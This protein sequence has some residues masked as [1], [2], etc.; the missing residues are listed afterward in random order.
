[1]N[2]VRLQALHSRELLVRYWAGQSKSILRITGAVYAGLKKEKEEILAAWTRQK[3]SRWR[4]LYAGLLPR[5]MHYIGLAK[6]NS[7]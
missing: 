4:V 3:K 6:G 5:K 1:M 7:V 2:A